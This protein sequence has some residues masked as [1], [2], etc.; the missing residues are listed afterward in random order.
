MI[1]C[2]RITGHK[3]CI[4][5]FY[6]ISYNVYTSTDIH[7]VTYFCVCLLS[8]PLW[9]MYVCINQAMPSRMLILSNKVRMYVNELLMHGD[10][11]LT[12]EM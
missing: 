10:L 7:Y 4:G 9:V 1:V 2:D 12:M 11:I 6:L 5:A 8:K 3:T